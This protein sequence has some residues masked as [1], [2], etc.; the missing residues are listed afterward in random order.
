VLVVRVG[1][2]GMPGKNCLQGGLDGRQRELKVGERVEG[3]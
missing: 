1:G 3:Y 2:R